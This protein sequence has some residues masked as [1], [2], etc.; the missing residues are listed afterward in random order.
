MPLLEVNDNVRLHDGNSW[1]VKGK[2]IEV[3]NPRSYIVLTHNGS[4]L[5]RNRVDILLSKRIIHDSYDSD[6]DSLLITISQDDIPNVI[7]LDIHQDPDNI[8][9][10]IDLMDEPIT[11]NDIDAEV[12]QPDVT[13]NQ[14]VP[15][16]AHPITTRS[17]RNVIPPMRFTDY[18]CS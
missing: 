11:N 2:I 1:S 15:P 4:K 8:P 12:L 18:E 16:V 9:D 14:E 10:D 3:I 6:D 17:G 7:D 13:D 5:R